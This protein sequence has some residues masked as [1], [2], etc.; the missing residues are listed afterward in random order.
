MEI[1]EWRPGKVMG[2]SHVGLVTG[3]G[4]FTLRRRRRGTRFT[5]REELRFP[6]KMGGPFGA[7]VAAP[8]LRRIWRRNLRALKAL[9]ESG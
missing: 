2:V 7:A 1:T 9:V 5:W 8:V 4:R 6:A 3:V